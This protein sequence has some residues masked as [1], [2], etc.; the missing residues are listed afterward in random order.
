MAGF[1]TPGGP[2]AACVGVPTCGT[3]QRSVPP[4]NWFNQIIASG[5]YDL[6]TT[7]RG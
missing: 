6:P 7:G 1:Q 5:G 3:G 4:D 2:I